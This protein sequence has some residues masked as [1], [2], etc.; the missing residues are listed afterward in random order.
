MGVLCHEA[1]LSQPVSLSL[2]LAVWCCPEVR[3]CLCPALNCSLW[4]QAGNFQALGLLFSGLRLMA[5]PATVCW[6]DTWWLR[7]EEWAMEE[8]FEGDPSVPA[9]PLT[10]PTRHR[11]SAPWPALGPTEP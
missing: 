6:A 10:L 9:S 8:A 11:P 7:A 4:F 2:A 3:A 1:G 5:H